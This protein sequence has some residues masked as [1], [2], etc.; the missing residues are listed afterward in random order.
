MD[1]IYK[2]I[3]KNSFKFHIGAGIGMILIGILAFFIDC[4][5][6]FPYFFYSKDKLSSLSSSEFEDG[7][8]CTCDCNIL[9]DYYAYNDD[10]RSYLAINQDGEYYGFFVN[11]NKTDV[12]DEIADATYDFFD[13][14]APLSS[15]SLKGKGYITEMDSKEKDYFIEF[16]G[17]Q[18]EEYHVKYYTFHMVT[19]WS[20]ITNEGGFRVF[21]FMI[22]GV[23]LVVWGFYLIISYILGAPKKAF[24]KATEEYNVNM[25]LLEND[26]HF[27]KQIGKAYIGNNYTIFFSGTKVGIMPHDLLVWA[28]LRKIVTQNKTYGIKTSTSTTY[29]LE[30]WDRNKKMNNVDVKSEELANQILDEMHTQAPHFLLGYTQEIADAANGRY[31]ELVAFVDDRKTHSQTLSEENQYIDDPALI[32]QDTTGPVNNQ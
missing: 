6:L 27:A 13:G 8:W 1:K 30:L 23:V 24:K 20:L 15:K 7:K 28:Y 29:R 3:K 4:P 19:A 14:K 10:G 18:F 11:N 26:M 21:M 9:F 16:F 32:Y 2:E 17:D 22:I 25:D 31:D 5:K 12:A